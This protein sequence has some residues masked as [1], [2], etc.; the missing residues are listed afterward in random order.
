MSQLAQLQ[1]SFQVYLLDDTLKSANNF[2]VNDAKLGAKK[3]LGIYHDAYRLRIV[4][5]LGNTYGKVKKLLGDAFFNTTA[6]AYLK[7]HPS[8]HPNLRW[9]GAHMP[10]FLKT[11]LPQHPVAAE[12]AAF[13]WAL[14]M[15]FDA[16]DA[17][18]LYLQ[19]LA[20]IAPENWADLRFK[21]HA[22]VQFIELELNTVAVWKALE[23][24]ETPPSA[25]PAQHHL[26]LIWR[27]HL[28]A[29]FRSIE[30]VE[31]M[32]LRLMIAGASFGDLCET[33][34]ESMGDNATSQAAQYLAG[35]LEAELISVLI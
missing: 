32:A 16:P 26:W 1:D 15:T 22:G 29:N 23:A 9:Y 14:A 21:F 10:T 17:Q 33:L 6:R 2:I 13:E 35:W 5:A 24:E 18:T 28:D 27:Q 4:E 8:L 30:D 3:R 11:A 19:D 25:V 34:F 12:L 31:A 20:T 7:Q